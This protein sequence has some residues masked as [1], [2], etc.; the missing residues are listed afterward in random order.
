MQTFVTMEENSFVT[1]QIQCRSYG[2]A[3]GALPPI[4]VN[5]KFLFWNIMQGQENRQ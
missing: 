1:W 4:L 5:Q 2:G 3:R